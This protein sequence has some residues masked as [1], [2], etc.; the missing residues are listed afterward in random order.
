MGTRAG[1]A[2]TMVGSAAWDVRDVADARRRRPDV[3]LSAWAAAHLLDVHGSANTSG[4]SA[5]LPGE[6]E[7]QFNVVR[8]TNAGRD[9][10]LWHCR[11]PLPVSWGPSGPTLD[12]DRHH[13]L[14]LDIPVQRGR[15][16]RVEHVGLPCTT[17]GVAVPEAALLPPFGVTL[18]AGT[19]V[20]DPGQLSPAVAALLDGP[21]RPLLRFGARYA[22]FELTFRFG[23]LLLRRN[24]YADGAGME[25]LLALLDLGARALCEAAAPLH[26]RS[27]F[28]VGLRPVVWPPTEPS[29][30]RAWPPSPLLDEVHRLAHRHG[31]QLEEPRHLHAAFPTLPVPGTAWAVLHG[32]LPEV[33]PS[34]RIALHTEAPLPD[35]LGR[36]ALLLPSGRAPR[37][38]PGGRQVLGSPVPMRFAVVDGIFAV[39]V[40]RSGLRGLGA[41]PALLGPGTALARSLGVPLD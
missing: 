35:G 40:T 38:P 26:A 41:V 16:D 30:H 5:A 32:R 1:I 14:R 8:G 21:L 33:R 39:W 13:D 27:P 6:P 24:G 12:G 19:P 10:C 4:W 22:V 25:E 29:A 18:R 23:A 2:R 20:G 11:H 7:L 15:P 31:L 34:A 17:A 9:V 28:A 36:T 3:D 37:T